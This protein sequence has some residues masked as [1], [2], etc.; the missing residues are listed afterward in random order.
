MRKN[1]ADGTS[2]LE[3]MSPLVFLMTYA[4]NQHTQTW[5]SSAYVLVK[6]LISTILKI[7]KDPYSPEPTHVTAVH[8]ST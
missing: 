2:I 3:G 5:K 4:H 8:L 1:N 6:P 7:G